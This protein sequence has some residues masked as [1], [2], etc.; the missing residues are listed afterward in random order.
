KSL[1][2]TVISIVALFYGLSFVLNTQTPISAVVSCSMV[3]NVNR[4]DLIVVQGSQDYVAPLS[5]SGDVVPLFRPETEILFKG[6]PAGKMNG[7][8]FS[9]CYGRIDPLCIQFRDNPSAFAERRGMFTFNYGECWRSSGKEACVVSISAG[10]QSYDLRQGNAGDVIVYRPEEGTLFSTLGDTIHRA[11]V[12][13]VDGNNTYYLTKGDNNNV[14]DVQFY[15]GLYNTP[16]EKAQVLGK[17]ILKVPF[18]GYY[19]IFITPYLSEGE[20]CSKPLSFTPQ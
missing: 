9:Y 18:L 6:K 7:S 13:V 15:K 17:V 8:L 10:N 1:A 2:I 16:P 5:A 12:K 14:F 4:G 3:P 20:L 11:I 19:K